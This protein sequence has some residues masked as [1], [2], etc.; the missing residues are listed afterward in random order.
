MGLAIKKR[1]NLYVF[2][3]EDIKALFKETLFL[4]CKYLLCL[5]TCLST[6]ATHRSCSSPSTSYL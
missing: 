3:A 5:V 4:V 2:V 1:V 6:K